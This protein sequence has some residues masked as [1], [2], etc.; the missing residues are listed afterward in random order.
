MGLAQEVE[1]SGVSLPVIQSSE[2]T[3]CLVPLFLS[4]APWKS[5]CAYEMLNSFHALGSYKYQEKSNPQKRTRKAS[6]QTL[7]PPAWEPVSRSTTAASGSGMQVSANTHRLLQPTALGLWV[8]GLQGSW[9]YGVKC[10]EGQFIFQAGSL[11]S[12]GSFQ[13]PCFFFL[14]VKASNHRNNV[15]GWTIIYHHEL[16]LPVYF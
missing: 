13:S 5:C 3:P 9:Q 1:G 10:K 14:C 4:A 7:C 11:R 8:H 2:I 12:S 15:V 6:M 16:P